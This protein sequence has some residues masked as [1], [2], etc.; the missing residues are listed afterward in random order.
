MGRWRE[1]TMERRTTTIMFIDL[2][3]SL[4]AI[5]FLI[6]LFFLLNPQ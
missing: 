6:T 1:V 2:E 4:S 3:G 5:H